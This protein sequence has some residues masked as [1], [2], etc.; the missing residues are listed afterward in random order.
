MKIGLEVLSRFIRVPRTGPRALRDLLDDLGIEVKRQEESEI[1]TLFTLELLANR[2]DH[3]CYAG[4]AR[5]ISGRTGDALCTPERATLQ[6]DASPVP[7]SIQTPRCLIY[8]ITRLERRREGTLADVDL[9][10]IRCARQNVVHPAVDATNLANLE[11]GQPTHAFDADKIVGTIALRLSRAGERAWPLFTA[12]PREIPEGLLVVADDE[13]ILAIAGVIGCEESKTTAA[14]TTVLLESA[15]FDPVSVRKA[16]RALMIHTDSSARFERGSDPSAPLVGAGRV[17]HLLQTAGWEIVGSTGCFGDWQDPARTLEVSTSSLSSFL[18]V[19]LDTDEVV[20]RLSR[21]GFDC[22][23]DG[24][25]VSVRVPPHRLW[26]VDKVADIAEE[27]AKSIGYSDT[28]VS[29]PRI[30]RGAVPSRAEQRRVAIE[31]VLVANGFFEVFTDG[32]YGRDLFERL[33]LPEGHAYADHVETLNSLDRGYSLLKSQCIA[34]ATETV[35]TNLR[36][37]RR[38]IKAWE[39]TRTFH[40]DASAPNGVGTERDVLWLVANGPQRDPAWDARCADVDLWWMKGLVAQLGAAVGLVIDIQ[41]G[42]DGP[43]GPLLHPGRCATLSVNGSPVGAFG[44]IHPQ[45]CQ[46]FKIKRDRPLYLEVAAEVFAA[47]PVRIAFEE[48]PETPPIE[49]SLAFTLPVTGFEAGAV[50]AA[51]REVGGSRLVSVEVTDRF[52][53]DEDG[54]PR[55]TLTWLLR[56]AAARG[57]TADDLNRFVDGLVAAVTERYGAAGVKQRA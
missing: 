43:L 39:L 55:R 22:R 13:K 10:P 21:Y 12:E 18:D 17:A 33:G 25:R 41:P 49:R 24:D 16:S 27:L 14:T 6:V 20:A 36:F 32:F 8:T 5:E 40:R 15:C 1:G 34:Q 31:D 52:L 19:A 23:A 57:Q 56:L 47:S 35:A 51:L 29:L 28:P 54:Q 45:V 46:A 26:D 48:P 11:L 3:H 37:Q 9:L 7:V 44:E 42:V 50:T 38:S 2:G 30:D 4:I 53:H